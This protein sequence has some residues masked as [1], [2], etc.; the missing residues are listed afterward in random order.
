MENVVR[1]E[2]LPD[3]INRTLLA[4]REGVALARKSGLLT[5]FPEKVDFDMT[6]I[7]TWQSPDLAVVST[8]TSTSNDAGTSTSTQD[9][10]GTRTESSA[11]TSSSSDSN[12][13]NGTNASYTY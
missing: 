2:D 9:G 11:G 4:I 13:S 1:I 7:G 3:F 8:D 10:S 5:E 6:V 12:N